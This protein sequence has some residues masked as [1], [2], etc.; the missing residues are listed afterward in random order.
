MNNDRASF[1]VPQHQYSSTS[2]YT[3]NVV[4]E[5][6]IEVESSDGQRITANIDPDFTTREVLD[7]WHQGIQGSENRDTK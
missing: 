4:K 2:D 5:Y 6:S 1:D 7:S 3:A